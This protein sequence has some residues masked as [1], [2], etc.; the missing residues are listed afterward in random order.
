MKCPSRG[1]K[2]LEKDSNTVTQNFHSQSSQDAVAPSIKGVERNATWRMSLRTAMFLFT[3]AITLLAIII[4]LARKDEGCDTMSTA[5]T[6]TINAGR[7]VGTTTTIAGPTGMITVNKFLGIPYATSPTGSLRFAPPQAPTNWTTRDTKEFGNSCIQVF[8]PPSQ[9]DFVEAVFNNPP[10]RNEDEDCLF[11]NVFAPEKAWDVDSPPFPVLYWI[12][13]G[14]WKSGSAGHPWYDG[15]RF[16]ALEDII[17]VSVN[18]RTNVFGLPISPTVTNLTERNVALLDQRAGL[19]WVQENIHHFGGNHSR[20]TIAGES[21]G[22]YAVGLLVT[23]FAPDTPRPF[24]AAIMQSGVYAYLPF[25][26]CDDTNYNA[27]N[28]LTASLNCT[29]SSESARFNCVQHER[30]ASQIKH[31]QQ[32]D[33]T[34]SFAQA[35]DNITAVSDPRTRLEAGNI[36]HVPVL[37]GSNTDDGGVFVFGYG[38]DTD[39]FFDTMWPGL[40]ALKA[41]VLAAYPLGSGGRTDE[42]MRLQQIQTDCMFHCPTVWYAE[43]CSEYM[44]TYHYLF[45]ASFASTRAQWPAWPTKYQRAYHASEIQLVF[46]TYPGADS[47]SIM[48]EPG[49]Q[50]LSDTMRRA[51]ANFVKDPNQAPME[52]WVKVGAA[53]DGK[54]VMAF[55]VDGKGRWGMVDDDDRNRCEVWR[56]LGLRDLHR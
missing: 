35:C 6:A 12:H 4:V 48:V 37:L 7:I 56:G 9:R 38:N 13:G 11:I 53:G 2:W 23:S 3:I 43:T 41:T 24:Q 44:P 5:P 40:R 28:T 34:I 18:Y 10:P 14:G 47:D 45:N 21:A 33:S 29:G 39:A 25:P 42:Q 8:A 17:V 27:W 22:G 36:A 52:E 46:N 15:S 55:G 19:Q 49:Q 54:D 16:A 1:K 32:L 30:T 26:D 51:W 20:V 50:E 31:A